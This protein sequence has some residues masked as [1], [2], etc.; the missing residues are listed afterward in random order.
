MTD[1][2]VSVES[3]E[4]KSVWQFFAGLAAVP[5]P[6][7]HEQKVRQHVLALA[8]KL[9]LAAREDGVGN[10]VI[11]V[12]ATPGH[13]NAPATVLQGHLDMVGEK[14][15]ATVHDFEKDPIRLVI[16][17]EAGGQ[18]IVRADG[19]TLGADNGIGVAMGLAVATDRSAVHGPLE[20]LLTVDEEMG[21]SGAK[22]LTAD[23][24]KGRR[25]LNLDSEE[26]DAIYIG[27]AGGMDTTLTFEFGIQP[28]PPKAELCRVTVTGLRGGHSGGDIHE[29]RGN[30]IKL[31]A[32]TLHGAGLKKLRLATAAGG[33]KRNAIP[34]EAS[35]IVCGPKRMAGK[36]K[37]SA[38]QVQADA[39]AES[40]EDKLT[41]N[42]EVVGPGDVKGVTS[43]RDGMKFLAVLL[44]APSGVINMHPKVEKLVQTSNN[45]STIVPEVA[46][47]KLTLAVGLLSRSSSRSLL[48][49]VAHQLASIGLVSGAR[50]EQ[51]GEYPGWEPNVDSPLLATCRKLYEQVFGVPPKVLAMHAGLE[52]GIIGE[53]VG[54]GMDMVSFGPAIKGAHSPDERVYVASVQ[55]S[56]KFLTAVLAELAKG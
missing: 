16:D 50:I 37:K 11:D 28:P 30:A 52:C 19:T 53:R 21:L 13:E 20:L 56:Y 47:G 31:L 33:S 24:F 6:S 18:Q 12:P 32:R 34:R 15:S 2:S 3:L 38:A 29:N 45:L 40:Y 8:A 27:C 14:N 4:P 9:G 26:D 46:D 7:K 1:S 10:I 35:A 44:A 22:V 41:I 39:S 49:L 25:M 51:G 23:F 55:K 48:H 5:R 36:L 17:Q 43:P 54:G 42:V